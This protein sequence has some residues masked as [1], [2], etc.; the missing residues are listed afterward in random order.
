[1]MCTLIATINS[2]F[3]KNKNKGKPIIKKSFDI[4]GEQITYNSIALYYEAKCDHILM[5]KFP[6]LAKVLIRISMIF[7]EVMII[8]ILIV[9]GFILVFQA[10]NIMYWLFLIFS[11]ILQVSVISFNEYSIKHA[12]RC[13]IESCTL[14]IYSGIVLFSQIAYTFITDK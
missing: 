4:K 10:P 9:Q 5:M 12:R 3:A 11:M 13:I 1:M 8:G 14:R 7:S 2:F 6:T